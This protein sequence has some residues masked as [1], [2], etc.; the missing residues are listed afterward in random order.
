[1]PVYCG[2]CAA[3]HAEI[4]PTQ[5]VDRELCWEIL[6]DGRR[7]ADFAL[8]YRVNTP[9]SMRLPGIL[10][11]HSGSMRFEFYRR[12]IVRDG[13]RQVRAA[14]LTPSSAESNPYSAATAVGST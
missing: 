7:K 14:A 4:V 2:N 9:K 13:K 10:P 1:V 12:E 11:G 8:K 5:L 6:C 3:R